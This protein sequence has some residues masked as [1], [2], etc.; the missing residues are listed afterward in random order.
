MVSILFPSNTV[1]GHLGGVMIGSF[2]GVFAG[3]IVHTSHYMYHL[4]PTLDLTF[5][6]SI[7]CLD[8]SV[9]D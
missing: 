9:P 1:L 4:F 3:M 8:Y 2:L 6:L 7:L 5:R